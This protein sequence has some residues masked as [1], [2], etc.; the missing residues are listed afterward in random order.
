MADK[1]PKLVFL[2]GCPRSGTTLLQSMLASHPD[3]AS[4][5]ETKF[6]DHMEPWFEPKRMGWGMVSRRLRVRLE[7]FFRDELD[8]PELIDQLPRIFIFKGHY[9]RRFIKILR[10]LAK[11][12]YKSVLLE[13]TPEHI[14]YIDYIEKFFPDAKIIHILRGGPDVIASLYQVTHQY[15]Q[16]WDGAWDIERCIKRW[17]ESIEISFKHSG[18]PNHI[19]VR[20][21]D[22]L[23]NPA[24]LVEGLCEFIGIYFYPKI[25]EDYSLA[26]KKVSFEAAGRTVRQSIQANHSG[27]FNS[28]FSPSQQEYILEQTR[29]I[30][31]DQ[32][33]IFYSPFSQSSS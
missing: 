19:L 16:W 28:L 7:G 4:F 21:E 22:L 26:A 23:K 29:S 2:V 15:P 12:Q 20:Y 27:K 30:D 10:T 24:F 18:K 17:V 5:P 9:S 25:I 31:L 14:F 33:E 8:Q 32:P 13:K 1:L 6:F 11:Q 3:V